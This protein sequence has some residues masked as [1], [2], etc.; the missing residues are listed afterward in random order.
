MSLSRDVARRVKQLRRERGWSQN[1]LERRAAFSP[2]QINRIESGE[3][4]RDLSL[5]SAAKLASA[6][7]VTIDFLVS[8]RRKGE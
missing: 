1:E 5:E 7:G 3:R 4:A 8:G 6:L 2:G